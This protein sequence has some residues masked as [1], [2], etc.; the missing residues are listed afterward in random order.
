MLGGMQLQ[1]KELNLVTAKEAGKALY[2]T[3]GMIH[4]WIRKGRLKRYQNPNG[5][6]FLVDLD[7]ARIASKWK[8]NVLEANPDLIT[9]DEAAEMLYLTRKAVNYHINQGRLKK[10][11][12]LGSDK[13]YLVHRDEV[14]ELSYREP[15]YIN[16]NRN[17]KL[18]EKALAQKKDKRG[19]FSR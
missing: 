7:E 11:Y 8:E 10:Y 2:V 13:H 9:L 18:R 4:Y 14:V 1:E 3:A 17:Q 15:Y 16:E 12:V 5:W 19:K 6:N